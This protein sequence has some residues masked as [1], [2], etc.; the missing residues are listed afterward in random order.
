M[1]SIPGTLRGSNTSYSGSFVVPLG[2][3][4]GLS[5]GLFWDSEV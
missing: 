2:V 4:C 3:R 1:S 5:R